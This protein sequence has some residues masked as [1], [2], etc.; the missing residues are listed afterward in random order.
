MKLHLFEGGE[1]E[2]A[3]GTLVSYC[4]EGLGGMDGEGVILN[5]LQ[6]ILKVLVRDS[7]L[8]LIVILILK[9]ILKLILIL[10]RVQGEV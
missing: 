4:G 9:L 3:F 1:S 2:I 10:G 5:I 7:I 8:I 6:L